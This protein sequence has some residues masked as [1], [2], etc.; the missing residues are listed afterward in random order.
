MTHNHCANLP[1]YSCFLS[2]ML[3]M[4]VSQFIPRSLR[5]AYCDGASINSIMKD[6][7]PCSIRPPSSAD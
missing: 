7:V 5:Q 6:V 2:E 1:E 3:P 4:T